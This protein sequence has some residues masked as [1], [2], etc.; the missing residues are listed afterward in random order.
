MPVCGVAGWCEIFSLSEF[1]AVT[2][3]TS[4]LGFSLANIRGRKYQRVFDSC[5]RL[6]LLPSEHI[7]VLLLRF[8]AATT[9][10]L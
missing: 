10:N 7:E 8:Q 3:D 2:V 9:L 4:K 1:A 5:I 6:E